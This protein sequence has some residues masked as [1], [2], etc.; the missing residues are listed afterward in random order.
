[1]KIKIL[2][3][4]CGLALPI[5]SNAGNVCPGIFSSA[6]DYQKNII[7]I[8]ADTTQHKAIRIDDFFF[9]PY[10]LIKTSNGKQK[11]PQNDVF[12]VR[13]PNNTVYRIVNNANYQLLDTSCICIYSKE[14]RISIPKRTA[15]SIRY[16]YKKVIE[17]FFSTAISDSIQQLNMTNLRLTLLRDKEFDN[18]LTS[19]FQTEESLVERNQK[20][21]FNL[22]VFLIQLSTNL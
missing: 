21:Q 7:S 15:H 11:I 6:E 16:E 3:L 19:H 10:V 20:G 4:Y 13:M 14:K 12:A 9:R 1:M 18:K 2:L 22:N 17:F 8:V 5:I